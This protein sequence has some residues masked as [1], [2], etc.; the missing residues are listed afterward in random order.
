MNNADGVFTHNLPQFGYLR[1][2]REKLTQLKLGDP[3]NDK[4][5]HDPL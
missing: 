4:K 3:P 2:N 5:R 1:V